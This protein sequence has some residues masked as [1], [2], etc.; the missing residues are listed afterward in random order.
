MYFTNPPTLPVCLIYVK[1]K[2]QNYVFVFYPVLAIL[3]VLTSNVNS[4]DLYFSVFF[5]ISQP[6]HFTCFFA[7]CQQINP[8][9]CFFASSRFGRFLLLGLSPHPNSALDSPNSQFQPLFKHLS[10]PICSSRDLPMSSNEDQFTLRP[11]ITRRY[12]IH[13]TDWTP[14]WQLAQAVQSLRRYHWSQAS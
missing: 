9:T 6:M 3:P 10:V 8:R 14:C 11:C 13:L 5:Y 1:D 2:F 12:S 7:E 4:Q